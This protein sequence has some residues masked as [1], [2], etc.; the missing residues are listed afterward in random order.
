MLAVV[1][2]APWVAEVFS[3]VPPVLPSSVVLAV[4]PPASVA[5]VVWFVLTVV[6]SGD[7]L[8]VAPPSVVVRTAPS[9][10]SFVLFVVA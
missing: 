2:F 9:V 8:V 4:V 1:P 5:T 3:V 6:A 7:A 10:V